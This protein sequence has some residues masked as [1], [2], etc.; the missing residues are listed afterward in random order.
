MYGKESKR[1]EGS[2]KKPYRFF[3]HNYHF[4]GDNNG[5]SDKILAKKLEA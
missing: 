4:G 5:N 1:K 3:K 2:N